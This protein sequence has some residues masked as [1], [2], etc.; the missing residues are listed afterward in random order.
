MGY[1]YWV[2]AAGVQC[3]TSAYLK[4]LYDKKVLLLYVR[5]NQI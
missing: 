3:K 1:L 5:R 2:L 4:A